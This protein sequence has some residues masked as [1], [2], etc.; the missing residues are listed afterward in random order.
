MTTKPTL[1]ELTRAE[2]YS[3]CHGYTPEGDPVAELAICFWLSQV[4]S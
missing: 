4:L 2:L 3:E 1:A